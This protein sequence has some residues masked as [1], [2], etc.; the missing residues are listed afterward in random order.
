MRPGA[1]VERTL[2]RLSRNPLILSIVVGTL[3][4][5]TGLGLP[6]SLA[7]PLGM[8]GR[9]TA[10]VALVTLGA[11]LYGRDYRAFLPALGLAAPAS[12]SSP[13]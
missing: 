7:V 3:L 9:T 1:A 5:A 6:S 12:L 2:R 13:A 4:A 11:F 8:L 10:A